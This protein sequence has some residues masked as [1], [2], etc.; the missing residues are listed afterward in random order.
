MHVRKGDLVEVMSGEDRGKRAA[1]IRALPKDNQVVVEKV[2]VVYKHLKKSGK[3][4]QGGRLEVEA[5]INASK[6]L[7]VCPSCNRGV[8]TGR[9]LKEDG[10]KVRV[11][12]KCK[13]ELG[14][15][16]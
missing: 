2:N 15:I 3:H 16:S 10:T 8:R 11:C 1:V 6:V 7:L 13:K 4:P 14:R 5:P 9:L 12:K